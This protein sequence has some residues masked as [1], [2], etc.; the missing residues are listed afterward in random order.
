MQSSLLRAKLHRPGQA[1]AAIPRLRLLR[2]LQGGLSCKVTL[3]SAAAG[4]GKST[5]LS[6]WL[7]QLIA[8]P[9][10]PEAIKAGWLTV[11][12]T[13][14][15]LPRFLHYLVAAIEVCFPR[16]CAAVIALLQENPAP[17][18]EAVADALTNAVASL[19]GRFVLAL[20]DLHAIDDSA[21]YALLARLIQFAPPSFHLTLSTRVDP[22]LPLNRWRAQGQLNEL[23]QAE[24]CFTLEEASAFLEKSLASPPTEEVV[25]ALHNYTEGWPVGMRLAALAL[26][27]HT[28]PTAFLT[29][30]AANSDRFALD[31]LRDDVLDQQPEAVQEFL[32][33]TA[34]LNRFCPALCAALLQMDGASA[35]KLLNAVERANLFLVDLSSPPL[36]YRYHHQFQSM[37]LSKL[38]ERYDRE[39][40]AVLHRRA[41]AWLADHAEIREALEYLTAID[42]FD[43]AA[44]LLESQRIALVNQGRAQ[45]LTDALTLLP[46]RLINERPVL[47]VSAAWVHSWRWESAQCNAAIQRAEQLLSEG[48]TRLE[49]STRKTIQ[50]E[51]VALRCTLDHALE[52]R[53]VSLA[54]IH[55]TWV[56]A[57]PYLTRIP[58]NLVE[59]LAERCQCLGDVASGLAMINAALEQNSEWPLSTR[60]GL[61]GIRALMQFWDGNL[62]AAERGFQAN[63]HLAQQN[64]FAAAMALSQLVLGVI[65]GVRHQL[66]VSERYLLQV[67]DDLY[68]E[69]ARFAMLS[70]SKLIELYAF[71]GRPDRASRLVERFKEHA[72]RVGLRYLHD[73]A[74]ALEAE[75]A[76]A[77]G[78][79][80]RALGWALTGLD[81]GMNYTAG[82]RLPVI[83]ARILLA[84]G[85]PASL[86][87]ASQTLQALIRYVESQHRRYYLVEAF[88]LHALAQARLG[89]MDAALAELDKAV[90]LA[91]PNGMV[92]QFIQQ[93]EPMKR[94]LIV[95]RKQSEH[96]QWV[97][98]LLTAFPTN[99]A[100]APMAELPELLT[101]REGDVLRLMAAGLTNKEIAR[102]LVISAHTVRNHTANI[103]GKLQVENRVQA[104]ERA[105]K[106]DLLPP[107]N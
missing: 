65:A 72:G 77:C 7:D 42:D 23:R 98:L 5:L 93:G 84:E 99:G 11:D 104:V 43:A 80:P 58:S 1:T 15:Q 17:S 8:Q 60:C 24:L 29:D 59:A 45:E 47:L 106:L 95:L 102:R 82:D 71:Q 14:N 41:A 37:L 67:L 56:S 68:V 74:A 78:D 40:I 64:G 52:G 63:L 3:V 107:V 22:P 28:D 87:A 2:R 4:S 100:V 55:A 27:G 36:W 75:F 92:G 34:I 85:S 89:R 18:I 10:S 33:R 44:D 53:G 91:A 48:G 35:E 39:A 83:R 16:S 12:E 101:E 46:E 32:M 105:R 30:V 86:R 38:N 9:A 50:L 69:N 103:F 21:I 31:Y 20:D 51:L 81:E 62:L 61:L 70:V 54:H 13:D 88:G 94:L 57:Q 49:E 79:L 73:Y 25:A 6:A 26:R 97:D 66:D 76:M 96:T 90:Q 19:P